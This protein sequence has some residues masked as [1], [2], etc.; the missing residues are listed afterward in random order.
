M[1]AR[2][3]T[4]INLTSEL[5]RPNRMQ[6]IRINYDGRTSRWTSTPHLASYNSSSETNLRSAIQRKPTLA[7]K[8]LVEV[9]R[10]NYWKNNRLIAKRNSIESLESAPPPPREFDQCAAHYFPVVNYR[11]SSSREIARS[12]VKRLGIPLGLYTTAVSW[13]MSESYYIV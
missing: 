9:G 13:K 11:S 7:M 2:K 8:M 6:S 10:L 4:G 12:T 1:C 3:Q 5:G